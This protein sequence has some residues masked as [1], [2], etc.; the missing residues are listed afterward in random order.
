ML[1]YFHCSFFHLFNHLSLAQAGGRYLGGGRKEAF[2]KTVLFSGKKERGGFEYDCSHLFSCT[3]PISAVCMCKNYPLPHYFLPSSWIWKT[4]KAVLEEREVALTIKELD[5]AESVEKS[6]RLP[7][8]SQ[9]S[10]L[11]TL[12]YSSCLVYMV[13]LW[14]AWS[15]LMFLKLI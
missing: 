3:R 8:Q 9:I 1:G 15:S 5:M 13:C 7:A 11:I 12:R 6:V 10:H 14:P 4:K 2:S